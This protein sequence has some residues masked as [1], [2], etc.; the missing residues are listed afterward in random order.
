MKRPI[1]KKISKRKA[2]LGWHFANETE[3]LRFGDGRK[4]EVGTTHKVDCTPILCKLGLHASK[5][6]REA[7]NYAPGNILFRVQL[8]G[9]IIHGDDKSVA[10]S[11]KYLARVDAELILREFARKCALQVIH[12]WKCPQVVQDY[13]ESGDESLRSAARSAARSAIRRVA[14]SATR[15]VAWSAAERGA[16]SAAYSAARSAA[17]KVAWSAAWKVAWSAAWSAAESAAYSAAYSAA[18]SATRRVAWS[19]AW[20]AARR[21]AWSAQSKMLDKMV[22][23]AIKKQGGR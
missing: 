6:V 13:L 14:W 17:W 16:Y 12:L 21:V 7:L 19:A 3:T 23:D 1:K 22:L 18:R 2:W 4:I 10:T 8:G 15:R 20:S 5:I 11:R 9:K